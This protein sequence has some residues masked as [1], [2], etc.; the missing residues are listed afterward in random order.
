MTF[1]SQVSL[2]I[3]PSL[4]YVPLIKPTED[5]S[6]Y[7]RTEE[8]DISMLSKVKTDVVFL[9]QVKDI[10]PSGIPLEPEKQVGTFVQVIGKS[11]QMEGSIRP[12]FFRGVAT[13]VSKLFN[14][15]QPTHA[16]FGQKD[17]QQC[18]V[19]RSMV[20]DLHF[21]IDVQ[22]CKTIREPDGLAMSSRNRYLSPDEREASVILYKA[23]STAESAFNQGIRNKKQLVNV[24][25]TVLRSERRVSLQYW[26]IADPVTLN[27]VDSISSSGAILSGAILVGKTRIIDNVLLGMET[28]KL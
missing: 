19:I 23:L 24:L 14:I 13:V 3:L 22:I 28:A 16:F 17:V 27:E 9:P 6:K 8:D 11:H 15:I 4:L 7:P 2:L 26:S 10:Y 5:L 12:H 18:C 21:P 20:K 1:L 25:D